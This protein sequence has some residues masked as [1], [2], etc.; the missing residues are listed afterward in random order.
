METKERYF[1]FPV[2]LLTDFMKDSKDAL[3]NISDY[4][5]YA[6]CLKLE[7]GNDLEMMRSSAKYYNIKL[8]NV[9]ASLKNG[10][11][12]YQSISETSPKVGINLK[13]WWEYYGGGK[14]E[15]ENV[16][17]LAHLAIKSIIQNHSCCKITND[18]LFSR[19]S[20]FTTVVKPDMFTYQLTKYYNE[21]Q[22]SKKIKPFLIHQWYLVTYSFHTRGFWVSY[23]MSL[24][25]LVL[26]V[27][28]RRKSTKEN[29][30][31]KQVRELRE[32]ALLKLN[33]L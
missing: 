24:E 19:M 26:E 6:H 31:K 9:G 12:L 32:K 7:H 4:A 16:C 18:Y 13:T 1:N 23:K 2:Q 14:S 8:Y 25:D 28:K 21:Y 17:L 22:I 15:F 3:N 10:R 29:Q 30:Y 20:G 27:E 33:A 11:N 5:V